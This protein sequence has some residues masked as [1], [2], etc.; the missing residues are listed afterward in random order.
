MISAT[1]F[2]TPIGRVGIGFSGPRCAVIQLPEAD[3]EKTR[4]RMSKLLAPRYAS[5]V[6]SFSAPLDRRQTRVIHLLEAHLSGGASKLDAILL[7]DDRLTD[8]TRAVYAVARRIRRGKVVTYGE[9]AVM[10]GKPNAAR[11][12]GRAM[13]TN[14]YPIVVPC[15]RV[16]GA[17]GAAGGFSAHGGLRTKARL[18]EIEDAPAATQIRAAIASAQ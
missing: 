2:D 16:V 9:L 8:F 7:D 17:S 5:E 14:P 4:T 11:A 3:D 1:L 15:H 12:V 6:V 13:A 18:L 10:L